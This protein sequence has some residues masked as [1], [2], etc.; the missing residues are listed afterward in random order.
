MGN[1]NHSNVT[2]RIDVFI[3]VV[4]CSLIFV[5]FDYEFVLTYLVGGL[6]LPYPGGSQASTVKSP[7]A[8]SPDA[9]ST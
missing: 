6:D 9:G 5:V 2:L 1:V 4:F 8:A 3:F 7:D